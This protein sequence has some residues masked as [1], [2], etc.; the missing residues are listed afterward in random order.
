MKNYRS[1]ISVLFLFIAYV[2]VTVLFAK[3][4][5]SVEVSETRKACV[6]ET[7]FNGPVYVKM[8]SYDYVVDS[9]WSFLN[10]LPYRLGDTAIKWKSHQDS[11]KSAEFS[12]P[13]NQKCCW[14]I[15]DSIPSN[16]DDHLDHNP[17]YPAIYASEENL[18]SLLENHYDITRELLPGYLVQL[19]E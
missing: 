16:C 9:K 7:N 1:I 4:H 13:E 11:V 10:F 12:F 2:L 6:D 17:Q 8:L 18:I 15:N 3:G 14:V 5:W 19:E